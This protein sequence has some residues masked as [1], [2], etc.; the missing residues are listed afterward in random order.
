[1][2]AVQPLRSNIGTEAI[3]LAAFA[4]LAG[5]SEIVG[6][7]AVARMD[8]FDVVNATDEVAAF[9][10]DVDVDECQEFQ[11]IESGIAAAG[12]VAVRNNSQHNVALAEIGRNL[13]IAVVTIGIIVGDLV[14]KA[15]AIGV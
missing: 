5:T 10:V 14:E 15:D 1:V 2:R 7:K 9:V 6:G 3:A 4:R 11:H 8:R 13:G 12:V